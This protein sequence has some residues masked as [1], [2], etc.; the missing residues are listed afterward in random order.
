[1]ATQR[2][3]WECSFCKRL[4]DDESQASACEEHHDNMSQ[5]KVIDGSDSDGIFPERV[6]LKS[7][8]DDEQL[9]EYTL[10]RKG[11]VAELYQTKDAQWQQV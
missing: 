2:T 5:F 3:Y 7:L 6:L 4:F 9:A 11:T 8:H 1:M 10:S